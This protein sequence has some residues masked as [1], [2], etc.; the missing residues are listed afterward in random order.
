MDVCHLVCLLLLGCF[1]LMA[2]SY[3]E[4]THKSSRKPAQG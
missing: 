1:P 3:Y 2:L 4:L